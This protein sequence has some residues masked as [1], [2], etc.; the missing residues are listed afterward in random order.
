[1]KLTKIFIS[2]LLFISFSFSVG[3]KKNVSASN[4]LVTSKNPLVD[5]NSSLIGDIGSF[6]DASGWTSVVGGTI[7]D[8]EGVL[9]P[10]SNNYANGHIWKEVAL[11]AGVTYTLSADIKVESSVSTS[12]AFLSIK[13]GSIS[14][15]G[16]SMEE[17][18]IW[19]SEDYNNHEIQFTPTSSGTYV[20]GLTRWM[21]STTIEDRNA[22]VYIDNVVLEGSSSLSSDNYNLVW[23]EEFDGNSLNTN[24]WEYELGSIRGI[25]QQHY[26]NDSENV[27]IDNGNL[28]LEVTDRA[29][30][31]YYPNPRDNSRIVKYNS[32]SVRSHGLQEFLYGRIE[33]SAKLPSGQGAFPAFWTLGADF[34]I[35]GDIVGDQGSWWPLCGEIDIME[36]IGTPY[37]SVSGNNTVYQT[38]HYSD[39]ENNYGMFAGSGT[40]YSLPSGIFNDEYHVFGMDWQPGKITWYVDDQVVRVLDYS[41]DPHAVFAIDRP[42]YIQLNFATGGAWPGVAGDNL[43]GQKFEIDYVYYA[44]NDQQKA[45]ADAY[46]SDAVEINGIQDIT[47]VEGG[48]PNLLETITTSNTS[49]VI[50]Y[51]VTN[52][53]MFE[54]TSTDNPMTTVDIVVAGKENATDLSK[55]APGTYTI[56]YSAVNDEINNYHTRKSATLTVEALEFPTDFMV[57]GI[58]NKPLDTIALPDGWT[59][60]EPNQLVTSDNLKVIVLY[61]GMEKE[62]DIKLYDVTSLQQEITTLEAIDRNMYTSDTIKKL[63]EAIQDAKDALK[64]GIVNDVIG[65]TSTLTI[66]KDSLE[67]NYAISGNNETIQSKDGATFTV[68]YLNHTDIKELRINDQ[69]LSTDH[70]SINGITTRAVLPSVTTIEIHSDYLQTLTTNEV[71]LDIMLISQESISIPFM[72]ATSD[73]TPPVI[74]ANNATITIGDTR[75]VKDVIGLSIMDN[76]DGDITNNAVISSNLDV[77]KVGK[78][79]VDIEVTDDA[80]NVANLSVAIEVVEESIVVVSTTPSTGDLMNT[81]IYALSMGVSAGLLIFFKKRYVK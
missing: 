60:K 32:G 55:L 51:T 12:Y 22:Y 6:D 75:D 81:S 14:A 20:I 49:D 38:I 21:D 2:L 19:P 45:A 7:V 80:G 66:V 61:N 72:L 11:E 13:I 41:S 74:I 50:D 31:D 63:D 29:I 77:N 54:S 4:D 34:A 65:A 43:A 15:P 53:P 39:E 3:T 64:I 33:I 16:A 78:Y 57:Q 23:V 35:D 5:I 70:Y 62:I 28:V 68:M 67:I 24:N 10:T 40:S 48:M 47:M 44:Q 73:V 52:A 69:L 30:E 59:F 27:Y 58:A 25:E 36:L 42:Q 56:Y 26:V 37:G 76:V 9:Q 1:M 8:G 46:Y 18:T 79:N 71:L 17:K